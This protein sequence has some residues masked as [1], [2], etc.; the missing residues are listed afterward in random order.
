MSTSK[1]KNLALNCSANIMSIKNLWNCIVITLNSRQMLCFDEIFIQDYSEINLFWKKSIMD[2]LSALKSWGSQR[3]NSSSK[4]ERILSSPR[5][6]RTSLLSRSC[7]RRNRSQNLTICR[8]NHV[9][10]D[11]NS[12]IKATSNSLPSSRASSVFGDSCLDLPKIQTSFRQS[13]YLDP[14]QG[15]IF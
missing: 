7:R 12:P 4:P 2:I 3:Q 8:E 15:E 11:K 1:N 9:K 10:N 5:F 13:D 14:F 6:S